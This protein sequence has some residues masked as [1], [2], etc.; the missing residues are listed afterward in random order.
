MVSLGELNLYT[1]IG[2]IQYKLEPMKDIFNQTQN[3]HKIYH[4]D[5]KG[6]IEIIEKQDNKRIIAGY[7]NVAVVDKQEQ[8]IPI[9]TLK[10]GIDS[11]LKDPHYSNL[12]LV[13]KNIQVGKIIDRYGLIKTRVDDKGLFIVCEIRKDT[14]VANEVWDSILDGEY[15]AFSIGCE[16]VTSHKECDSDKCITILDK[17]NIFEVSICSSPVNQESG[18]V[19]ISKS[20][21]ETSLD[22]VCDEC[23]N[24]VKEDMTKKSTKSE[25]KS[26]EKVE[27]ETKEEVEEK[28]DN[29]LVS[30][31]EE[32]ERKINALEGSLQ[33]S[34]KDEPEEE[35][36]KSEEPEEKAKKPKDEEE[37]DEEEM[38]E[39]EEEK[40]APFGSMDGDNQKTIPAP[41][42][43]DPTN[44]PNLGKSIEELIKSIDELNSKLSKESEI[45]ELKLENKALS[46][47]LEAF[48]KKVEV[49]TKSEDEV[50][51]KEEESNEPQTV[52]DE[53][54]EE[55]KKLETYNPI[56]IRHGEIYFEE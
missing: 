18:F 41:T 20:E 15:G 48:N 11:L 45:D 14:E 7:A 1:T 23:D 17:I 24:I 50:E 26:E 55:S 3:L 30:K 36:E 6:N 39:D 46:D 10:K 4:M 12:M 35:R 29:A 13:H 49:E 40:A 34:L 37:E 22:N 42:L 16:V 5:L 56:K 38:P 27:E 44:Y 28:T 43:I 21:Y 33:E 2:D 25:E 47:Q 54:E 51:E 31:I 9:E 53:D 19:V 8:F 52:K 32:L